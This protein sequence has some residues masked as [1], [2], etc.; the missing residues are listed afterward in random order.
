M[1]TFFL[2][3]PSKCALILISHLFF[4]NFHFINLL[5]PLFC[6]TQPHLPCVAAKIQISLM[7]QVLY[8]TSASETGHCLKKEMNLFFN[9]DLDIFST[10]FL[11]L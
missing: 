8:P 1:V 3:R 11:I 7:P 4:L 5:S 10:C 6:Q 9:A 2:L